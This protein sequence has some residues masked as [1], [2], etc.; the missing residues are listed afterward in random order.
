MRPV[1]LGFLAGVGALTV[2]LLAG[3]TYTSFRKDKVCIEAK[4]KGYQLEQCEGVTP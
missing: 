2:F 1:V 3:G 4:A